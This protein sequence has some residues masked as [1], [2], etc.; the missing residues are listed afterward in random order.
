MACEAKVHGH[1]RFASNDPLTFADRLAIIGA[2]CRAGLA[3]RAVQNCD[4]PMK[5]W[6]ILAKQAARDAL[7]RLALYRAGTGFR[8]TTP[9]WVE[10]NSAEAWVREA[11]RAHRFLKGNS[12][13]QTFGSVLVAA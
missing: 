12:Y 4:H 3:Q 13:S 5:P 1:L 11:I 2:E 8:S 10:L 6:H 9:Y 7:R